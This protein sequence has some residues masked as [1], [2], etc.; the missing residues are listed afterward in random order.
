MYYNEDDEIRKEN[1]QNWGLTKKL[2][3]AILVLVLLLAAAIYFIYVHN[4]KDD[5]S[6]KGVVET[7][8]DQGTKEAEVTFTEAQLAEVFKI[9]E[10]S[11][12]TY[13]YNSIASAYDEEAQT[14]RYHVFYEGTVK[15]GVDFSDIKME[16]DN[17]NKLIKL[18]LPEAEVLD[19]SIDAGTM[20][21][22]FTSEIYNTETIT[23]EA[24]NL[25]CLDLKCKLENEEQLYVTAKENA[26][27]TVEAL[28]KPW[29]EQ[30]DADYTVSI[31]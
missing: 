29:V 19:M 28:I 16:I 27:A 11:T 26:I 4:I 18:T 12:A 20:D 25:S 7:L 21:Y 6:G 9:S 22:I 8:I 5:D 15:V 31:R 14:V 23:Q 2:I 3:I 30:M 17:E 10:L 13:T 1:K 24:Y